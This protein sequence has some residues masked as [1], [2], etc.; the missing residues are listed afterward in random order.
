MDIWENE[1]IWVNG[2]GGKMW[3]RLYDSN[4]LVCNVK[5]NS[6]LNPTLARLP[7]LSRMESPTHGYDGF[8]WDGGSIRSL[9]DLITNMILRGCS[10][11]VIVAALFTEADAKAAISLRQIVSGTDA[12][13]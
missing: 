5:Q 6:I 11:N 9:V 8:Y 10:E 4:T 2:I 3:Y 13:W 12:L 1:K 7:Y